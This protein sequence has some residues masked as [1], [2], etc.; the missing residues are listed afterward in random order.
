MAAAAED[1]PPAEAW[2]TCSCSGSVRCSRGTG[3]DCVHRSCLHDYAT[4][5]DRLRVT[6]GAGQV[7]D[8]HV[9]RRRP[10]V[11]EVERAVAVPLVPDVLVVARDGV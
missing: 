2:G 4:A 8:V 9:T 6:G 1:A 7:A 5:Y 3:C 11:V 10:D